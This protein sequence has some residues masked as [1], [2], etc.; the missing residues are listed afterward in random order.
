MRPPERATALP[1]S[2]LSWLKRDSLSVGAG[3][4]FKTISSERRSYTPNERRAGGCSLGDQIFGSQRGDKLSFLS[5]GFQQ[6]HE[7]RELFIRKSVQ[8]VFRHA[9]YLYLVRVGNIPGIVR[10]AT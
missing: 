7:Y 1:L 6:R 3:T 10:D 5:D 9:L 4:N 2:R 8:I